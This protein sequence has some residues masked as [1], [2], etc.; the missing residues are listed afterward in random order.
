MQEKSFFH[1]PD[2]GFH[3]NRYKDTYPHAI[4]VAYFFGEEGKSLF[5]HRF[6][7]QNLNNLYFRV[8]ISASLAI[9][10][11]EETPIISQL[12]MAQELQMGRVKVKF[13]IGGF[14]YVISS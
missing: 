7:Q 9:S 5:L 11:K 1:H 4:N 12:P 14:N 13:K 10:G 3:S 6:C 8:I 2:Y